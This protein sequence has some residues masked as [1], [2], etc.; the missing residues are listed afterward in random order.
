MAFRPPGHD[1]SS[2]RCSEHENKASHYPGKDHGQAICTT[3]AESKGLYL[4]PCTSLAWIGRRVAETCIGVRASSRTVRSTGR[5]GSG[6]CGCHATY[7]GGVDSDW[8][9][10]P[11]Q[12]V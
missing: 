6:F 2:F 9:L 7:C 1:G 8:V 3:E 10:G 11:T 5:S 4:R 12:M